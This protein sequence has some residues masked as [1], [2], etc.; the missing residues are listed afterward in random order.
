MKSKLFKFLPVVI[1]FL[2]LGAHFLRYANYGMCAVCLTL[3]LLYFVRK[4]WIVH[5]F[6]TLLG[7]GV[8]VWI[9]TTLNIYS[10]RI[11]YGEDWQRA[12]LIM[13]TVTL[14]TLFSIL[15]FN[16]KEL[17]DHFDSPDS[18]GLAPVFSFLLTSSVLTFLQVYGDNPFLI[19][20]RFFR[21][22]GWMEI[23]ILALYAAFITGYS[24]DIEKH[25]EIRLKIWSLFS[26]V[27][28][29]QL[30][31]GLSGIE[32]FLMTGELHLPV[33]ALILGGP[34]YRFEGFFMPSLFLFTV[35]FVGPAWCSHLCYIGAWDNLF[36]EAESN[37]KN[38]P[39]WRHIARVII[40]LLVAGTA[41]LSNFMGVPVFP[42]VLMGAFFGLTG[43]AVM[44]FWSR[45]TGRMAHC[46][47]YCPIGLLAD[48]L[49]KISP[50]RLQIGKECTE[51]I[52][53]SDPC[54]YDALREKNIRERKPGITCT[55]CGDCLSTCPQNTIHYTFFNLSPEKARALFLVFIL[56][57]HSIFL[58]VA[59]I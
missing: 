18:T 8:I 28:F 9:D 22:W 52:K 11:A 54:R 26:F 15:V 39:D 50:F 48:I 35:I 1:S 49:G 29:L 57:L 42:A 55:L 5:I 10:Q 36:S 37:P 47:I 3:P 7:L 25:S 14:F 23:F 2:F 32:R 6:R 43:V 34:L 27:F 46:T 40:L 20:E 24:L 38:L 30:I 19:V 21:T 59:R 4:K 58:G 56:S 45:K 41:L 44:I 33:P 31:L 12:V 16:F 13:S 53:C 17:K 51:C